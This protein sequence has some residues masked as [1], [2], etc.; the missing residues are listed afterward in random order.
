MKWGRRSEPRGYH[1]GNLKEALVRAALELIATLPRDQAEAVLLRAV[2]G[3]DAVSAG[4]VLGKRPGA[5]RVAAHRGLRALGRRLDE[6]AEK[7]ATE[8]DSTGQ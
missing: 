7:A 5:V 1:H 4:K 2:V 3:L 8:V 6:D